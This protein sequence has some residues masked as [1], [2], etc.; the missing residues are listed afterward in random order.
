MIA[1]SYSIF[2]FN[3]QFENSF[4]FLSYFRY[5]G[6]T[7][8][9]HEL[10]YPDY[11]LHVTTDKETY[12]SKYKYFFDYH[13]E[14]GKIDLD[15]VEKKPLCHM[16]LYRMAPIFSGK[17]DR[18]IC[19][20]IDSL[21]TYRERQA[22]EVWIRNG[23]IAH[24]ITD[25]VSHTIPLLGGMCAF[26]C[27]ELKDRLGEGVDSFDAMLTLRGDID[28]SIK[29]TDQ[30]FLNSV[31]LPKIVDS[32]TEHYILGLPQS[33]RGD[34]YNYIEDIEIGI[35]IELKESNL[36]VNHIGQSGAVVEPVLLFFDKFLTRDQKLYYNKI[37]KQ[38][39]EVFYWQNN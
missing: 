22:V 38:Y 26:M 15:I 16:M 28:Y 37:E 27:K 10:I 34:C 30:V 3:E 9:Q 33:F 12:N 5:L 17:Y 21:A 32:F 1:V 6:L 18:V 4:D 25:S 29:G 2:G 19:R 24:G 20:D 14:N 31:I 35:P 11:A 7:I 13:V 8:R 39:K 36:L 23:R